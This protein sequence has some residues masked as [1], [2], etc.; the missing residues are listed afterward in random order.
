MRTLLT[1]TCIWVTILFLLPG[2]TRVDS[3]DLK[4]DV[5]YHQNYNIT[6]SK[7]DDATYVSA[8]FR[9]RSA[10]GARVMLANGSSV[11]MN[12]RTGATSDPFDRTLYTWQFAG[13]QDI[14]AVLTK[15]GKAIVN[16]TQLSDIGDVSFPATL[17][18]DISK[19]TGYTFVWEGPA[20]ATGERMYVGVAGRSTT[21]T[22]LNAS[23]EIEVS[24]AKAIITAEDLQLIAPGKLTLSLRRQKNMSL[25]AYD[26]DGTGFTSVTL[27]T[28]KEITLKN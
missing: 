23:N 21:D 19:S 13:L 26:G 11:T 14:N 17:A 10:G 2:C 25:D 16:T 27:I 7:T 4:E 12:G 15:N 5:P 9:V 20:L 1:C 22:S 3:N 28:A 24:G 6:F 18:A 8:Y